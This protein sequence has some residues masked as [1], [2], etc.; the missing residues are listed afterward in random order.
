MKYAIECRRREANE[1]ITI[2]RSCLSFDKRTANAA[3]LR[4]I[5][6]LLW[7]A[8]YMEKIY[9]SGGVIDEKCWYKNPADNH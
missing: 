8:V 9:A 2:S 3:Y 1:D 4:E 7:D 6:S 5:K